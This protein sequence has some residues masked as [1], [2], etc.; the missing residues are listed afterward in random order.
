MLLAVL[1]AKSSP[2]WPEPT[3]ERQLSQ[4]YVFILINLV[5]PS[6]PATMRVTKEMI[7][8]VFFLHR[9]HNSVII[10]LFLTI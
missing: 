4:W 9:G 8:F 3:K 10:V 2:G 7:I 5:L 6:A 1:G